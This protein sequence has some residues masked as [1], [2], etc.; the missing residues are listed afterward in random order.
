MINATP[1]ENKQAVFD[2]LKTCDDSDYL[3]LKYVVYGMEAHKIAKE[4]KRERRK[5]KAQK[6]N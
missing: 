6:E 2:Y 1:T 3:A 4:L 5:A